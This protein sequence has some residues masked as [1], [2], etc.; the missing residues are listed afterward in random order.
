[1]SVIAIDNSTLVTS[2]AGEGVPLRKPTGFAL[3]GYASR[4]G[5]K[6]QAMEL[7]RRW[8]A[9]EARSHASAAGRASAK[10][11]SPA[12]ARERATAAARAGV[13]KRLARLGS[14]RLLRKGEKL[15]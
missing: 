15:P 14:A 12:Q 13:A 4:A 11:L 10:K 9:E 6:G 5:R 1:M 8:S 3:P 7:C 2:L